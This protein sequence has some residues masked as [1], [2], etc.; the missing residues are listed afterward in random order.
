[1]LEGNRKNEWQSNEQMVDRASL[2]TGWAAAADKAGAKTQHQWN[3]HKRNKL[4]FPFYKYKLSKMNTMYC[5]EW[6]ST[7]YAGRLQF[8]EHTPA[9]IIK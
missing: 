4:L 8:R 6:T 5:G 3:S 9:K 7:S 1:M 2:Y